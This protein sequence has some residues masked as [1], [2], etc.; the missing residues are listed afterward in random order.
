M[1]S[2][3]LSTHTELWSEVDVHLVEAF[4]RCVGS[5]VPP[6]TARTAHVSMSVKLFVEVVTKIG[7]I[8]A[9]QQPN[10]EAVDGGESVVEGGIYLRFPYFFL[11]FWFWGPQSASQAR[12]I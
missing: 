11:F 1:A 2:Y 6:P 3:L 7:K 10:M 5:I 12:K 4:P 9:V 8:L